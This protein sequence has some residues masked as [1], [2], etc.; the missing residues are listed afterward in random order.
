MVS[1]EY[2][3]EGARLMIAGVAGS[4]AGK[5]EG[6]LNLLGA[7]FWINAGTFTVLLALMTFLIWLVNEVMYPPEA[8]D[9]EE[10]PS[11]LPLFLR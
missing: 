6:S 8:P 5:I 9:D 11:D 10:Q 7:Q 2:R 3:R 1:N 4:W